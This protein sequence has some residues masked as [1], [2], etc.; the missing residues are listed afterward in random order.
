MDK[1]AKDIAHHFPRRGFLGKGLVVSVDKFTTV[2]MYDKVQHY[3]QEE[4][5]ELTKERNLA[6]TKEKRDELT[7]IINYMNNVD[8][9]VV[10]ST[11]NGDDVKKFSDQGLSLIHI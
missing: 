11:N 1:V 7:K 5:K 4:I 2:K 10:I 3:W 8:M 6:N 9:A